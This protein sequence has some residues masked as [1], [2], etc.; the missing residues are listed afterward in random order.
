MKALLLLLALAGPPDKFPPVIV[1]VCGTCHAP[2]AVLQNR[3]DRKGW[4]ELV[5][6][7]IFKGAKAT[8]RERREIIA[9]LAAHFP[10]TAK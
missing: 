10:L 1:K 7:M 4:T 6:E 2:E 3:N 9:Y 5:D 8:P